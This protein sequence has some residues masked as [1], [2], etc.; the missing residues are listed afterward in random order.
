MCIRDRPK[1]TVDVAME[2][3]PQS[4][5]MER[6]N[7]GGRYQPESGKVLNAG[8]RFTRDQFQTPGLSQIDI[9]GQWPIAGGWYGVGR[10]NYSTKDQRMVETVTGLE[11][12]GGCWV[13]RVVFQH[14]VTQQNTSNTSFFV[15]LE[16]NGFTKV[17]T[18]PLDILK[19]SVPGYNVLNQQNYETSI[20][21]Q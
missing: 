7:F 9:S 10:V 21:D 13:G 18:S 16:F 6:F 4:R 1:T 2:Y 12:D 11:Y 3:N 14:L 17:G 20:L 19:R 15:Q 5:W 8:Y